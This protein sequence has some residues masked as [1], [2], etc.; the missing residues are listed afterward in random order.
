MS[1]WKNLTIKQKLIVKV[2][3][4]TVMFVTF[5]GWTQATINSV[6]VGGE[7]YDKIVQGKD[8]IADIAPPTL[9]ASE[10]YYLA[11]Q[12]IN[13]P[14][15]TKM[16]QLAEQI[17]QF[18][19]NYAKRLDYWTKELGP[20]PI[21]ERLSGRAHQSAQAMLDMIERDLVPAAMS[22]DKQK[23]TDIFKGQISAK[24]DDHNSAIS[25]FVAAVNE[26]NKNFEDDSVAYSS[27]SVWQFTGFAVVFLLF[28]LGFNIALATGIGTPLGYAATA[29]DA[30]SVGDF[31]KD[32]QYDSKDEVGIL[33]KSYSRLVAYLKTVAEA[34][35]GVSEGD[36]SVQIKAQSDRDTL[37]QNFNQALETLRN[38]V[39]ETQ[40]LSRSALAGQLGKRGNA[41]KFRG[42][43]AEVVDGMNGMLDAVT[44]PFNETTSVLQRVASR[45]LTAR[46]NSEYKGDFA[47][48]QQALNTAVNNLSEA[49]SQ[50][51]SSAEQV[52]SA[53]NE[54][55]SGS[56]S[57][58]QGASEQASALEDISSR[59][60][61]MSAMIR[62]NTASAKEARGLSEAARLSASQGVE[63][64]RNLSSAMDRIKQSSDSTA[65][66]VKTIDEIAFQTNLLALNAAVEAARAGD[67][68]RGFAVVAEEVRNL[69]MRS[70]EAAKNTANL[71]EESV[72]NAESGV[73]L[74]QEVLANLDEINQQ[75]NKVT[76]VMSEI[77]AASEQQTQSVEQID[78]AVVQLNQVT[79]QNAANSEQSAAASEELSGQS[80]E[81]L[82]MTASFQLQQSSG[83]TVAPTVRRMASGSGRR[84]ARAAAPA[85]P[86][87]NGHAGSAG[88]FAN[89]KDLIPFDD[90]Q[91]ADVLQDF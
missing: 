22:G 82:G 15:R 71:I 79:Q 76:E 62:Q 32:F 64:M 85:R 43:Y 69:A 46:I 35:R 55:S 70:A 58:A 18:R 17:K 68:G 1:V 74:N 33:S 14:D 6:K 2:T 49:M 8:F 50:V 60:Q 23:A 91:D 52:N 53:A 36:L 45:D 48:I 87:A 41:A 63:S 77:T 30:L 42:V 56:Q 66:I 9:N 7:R 37:A 4:L 89:G 84:A 39:A 11:S 73:S 5:V 65:K 10:P 61:K 3:I 31:S 88:G 19:S 86:T 25:E 80:E 47:K 12:M 34:S 28:V 83:Y 16:Q 72:K 38:L 24:F 81:L 59:L 67:A 21:K 20:G 57:L 78:T 90:S 75:V 54:I 27:S 29:L 51:V 13:E 40:D 44:T 26:R